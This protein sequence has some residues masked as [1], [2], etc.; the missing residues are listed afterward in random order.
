M[1]TN[2]PPAD[3]KPDVNADVERI[4][5]LEA[6]LEIAEDA[7]RAIVRGDYDNAH[8]AEGASKV[9]NTALERIRKAREA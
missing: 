5:K 9:A 8:S 3:W 6:Q 7:L 4:R 1:N 2:L